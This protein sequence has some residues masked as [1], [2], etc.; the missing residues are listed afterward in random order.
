[1]IHFPIKYKSVFYMKMNKKMI[2]SPIQGYNSST[3]M[4]WLQTCSLYKDS[5]G[6]WLTFY[7]KKCLSN[8]TYQTYQDLPCHI[9]RKYFSI[10]SRL[11]TTHPV[12]PF[13]HIRICMIV[14]FSLINLYKID[15]SNYSQTPLYPQLWDQVFGDITGF[16]NLTRSTYINTL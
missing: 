8:V 1:M 16:H 2:F 12:P 9:T 11:A 10:D 4:Q 13:V 5:V 14:L 6:A 15:I 3:S 7:T